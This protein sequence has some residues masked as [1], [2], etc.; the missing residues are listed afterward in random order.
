M[1]PSNSDFDSSF[2]TSC[3]S[4]FIKMPSPV[5]VGHAPNGLLKENIVGV[6]SGMLI[7]C[8]SQAKLCENC[9]SSPPITSTVIVPP[10]TAAAVSMLSARRER[11]PSF[12]TSLST[13]ISMLCFLFFSSF[14]S[15][16]KS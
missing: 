9:S 2:I 3:G 11:I 8:S 14:I 7:P 10:E 6:S 15:S 12:T 4:T 1:A 16:D 13:T 5:Q